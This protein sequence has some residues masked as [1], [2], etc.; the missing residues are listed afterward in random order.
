MIPTSN[1][2]QIHKFRKRRGGGSGTDN[3]RME[4]GGHKVICAPKDDTCSD[5]L[6]KHL[7]RAGR[8]G[9]ASINKS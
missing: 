8:G 1:L 2:G 7:K 4:R 5:N 9:Y 6:V 3:F